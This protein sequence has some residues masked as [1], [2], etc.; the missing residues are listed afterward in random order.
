MIIFALK[1][2]FN[3]EEN[4]QI[5]DIT[6]QKSLTGISM[7]KA[8]NEQPQLAGEL[9]SKTVEGM[10]SQ[11]AQTPVQPTDVSGITGTGKIINT[12]A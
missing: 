11:N 2:S 9:I 12:T 4:M 7:L 5:T 10:H 3:R 1:I 8:A 6:Y